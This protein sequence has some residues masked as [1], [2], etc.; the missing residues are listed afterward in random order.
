MSVH[1]YAVRWCG[2]YQ[3]IGCI[4]AT[5][6]TS[7]LLSEVTMHSVDEQTLLDS[8]N[9]AHM[10]FEEI[11]NE[12]GFNAY[13]DKIQESDAY[14]HKINHP[15]D[16]NALLLHCLSF[17]AFWL[18]SE[19]R[20]F[21][22]KNLFGIYLAQSGFAVLSDELHAFHRAHM[23]FDKA[24]LI[25]LIYSEFGVEV[26]DDN[27]ILHVLQEFSSESSMVHYIQQSVPCHCFDE[28]ASCYTIDNDLLRA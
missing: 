17:I 4:W 11:L 6:I 22:T 1:Y 13:M 9:C 16:P 5:L 15:L 28:L 20:P 2:H 19:N 14:L 25:K 27:C 10:Q 12:H 23:C 7:L 21:V 18:Q 3:Q 8:K 26:Q 24:I